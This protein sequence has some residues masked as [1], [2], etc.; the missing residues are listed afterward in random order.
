MMQIH[1]FVSLLE[2]TNSTFMT[3]LNAFAWGVTIDYGVNVP[4]FNHL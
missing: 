2:C 4:K 1:T 3:P